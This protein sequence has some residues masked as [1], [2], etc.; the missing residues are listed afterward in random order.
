[1]SR[2]PD[3]DSVVIQSFNEHETH[4][5]LIFIHRKRFHLNKVEL[6]KVAREAC[7]DEYKDYLVYSELAKHNKGK[8]HK[9]DEVFSQ[10]ANT[11]K[12]HYDF[13]KKF[14]VGKE[15]ATSKWGSRFIIF[16]SL[17]FGITFAIKFLEK[18]ET[19]TIE[20]YKSVAHLIPEEDK[21]FF[22]GMIIEEEKHEHDF[23]ND[24]QSSYVKYISFVILGLADAIVEISGIHAGSLGIYDST[25]LTGLAGI[26][27]G[28]AASIAM[29]SAAY[30]QAKQGFSGSAS[31]SAAFTGISYFASAVVLATPYFLTDNMI[32]AVF[33][34]ITFAVIIL[35][36][37]N[38]YNS[39]ITEK[40]FIR[41]FAEMISITF[42]AT[43]VLYL[44][45]QFIRSYFGITV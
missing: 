14:S 35:A 20:K 24:I 41:D 4:N 34:S 22:A 30:A 19:K 32:G 31:I 15:P 38:Y 44:L 2:A 29:A 5:S 23:R 25:R 18:H 36:V 33:A 37:T 26:V 12:K 6:E 17:L 28:A 1:L 16:I 40:S 39:V 10:L 13:W 21:A 11:E 7:E 45:G 9:F 8:N 3:G 27:A 43:I 42:G